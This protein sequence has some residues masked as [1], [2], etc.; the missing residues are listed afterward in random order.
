M[1]SYADHLQAAEPSTRVSP[2]WLY[3]KTHDPW[4]SARQ[5]SLCLLC[6]SKRASWPLDELTFGLALSGTAIGAF[7]GGAALGHL[8]DL[9]ALLELFGVLATV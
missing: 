9:A 5:T 6:V 3:Y 7:G 2:G 1:I 4:R 8:L